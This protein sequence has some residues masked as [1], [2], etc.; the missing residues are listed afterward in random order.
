[1]SRHL[2]LSLLFLAAIAPAHAALRELSM[3]SRKPWPADPSHFEL[4]EGHFSG[5]LDPEARQNRII[6]D[7][8]MAPRNDRGLVAYR[9]TFAILRP[10]GTA[11]GLLVYDVANR[12]RITPTAFSQGHVSV[13]SGW[14]GDLP[15]GPGIQ[16][17]EVPIARARDGGPVTWPVIVRFF[18]MPAGISP[19]SISRAG[20]RAALAG[21]HSL[22]QPARALV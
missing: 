16:S 15:V 2:L 8:S 5:D 6:N 17:I 19:R 10:L 20:R 1:M 18:N 21:A 12:G 14:Q 13:I 22:L 11:S 7:L 4:L 3:E 9:A